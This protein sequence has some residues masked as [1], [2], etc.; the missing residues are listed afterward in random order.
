M[1]KS[2]KNYK[3]ARKAAK[4]FYGDGFSFTPSALDDW[5]YQYGVSPF[6]QPTSAPRMEDLI[7][8]QKENGTLSIPDTN[9]DT[10][11]DHGTRNFIYGCLNNPIPRPS[12][13][14]GYIGRGSLDTDD[15]MIKRSD[16]IG[17]IEKSDA[18]FINNLCDENERHSLIGPTGLYL[19][20]GC[21]PIVTR[22]DKFNKQ[23]PVIGCLISDSIQFHTDFTSVNSSEWTLVESISNKDQLF[24]NVESSSHDHAVSDILTN[25]CFHSFGYISKNYD[26]TY[27][28]INALRS[29]YDITVNGYGKTKIDTNTFNE[30]LDYQIILVTAAEYRT[31]MR[32][33]AKIYGDMQPVQTCY[34]TISQR[35]YIGRLSGAYY[36]K[37]DEEGFYKL[38]GIS[39]NG[40]ILG[41]YFANTAVFA[42]LVSKSDMGYEGNNINHQLLTLHDMLVV[43]GEDVIMIIHVGNSD[44]LD[45]IISGLA[46]EIVEVSDTGNFIHE[47]DVKDP[48]E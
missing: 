31:W 7:Q 41:D 12:E 34:S 16:I 25:A 18:S 21:A 8:M 46:S 35:D 33:V 17:L 32:S 24:P 29:T 44:D 30:M 47:D 42:D 38:S 13:P 4:R 28:F 22:V 15:C 27:D 10:R 2:K 6:Y 11:F 20:N 23:I 43:K 3:R 45:H 36:F 5:M 14:I 37:D 39:S 1:S 40:V 26:N 19:K 9:E 48:E